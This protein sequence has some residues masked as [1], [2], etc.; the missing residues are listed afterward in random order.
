MGLDGKI[1]IV[2]G[3]SRGVGKAMAMGLAKSGAVVVVAARTEIETPHLRG[4]IGMTVEEIR[5]AGG[6]AL[7]V[8]CDVTDEAGVG[9][10]V[11]RVMDRFG[12]WIFS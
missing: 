6:E 4:T 12:R 9:R 5:Q 3:G 7:A 11:S 2:T 1:A 10:M 8:V